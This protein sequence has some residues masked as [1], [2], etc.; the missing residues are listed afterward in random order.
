M[1]AW[2]EITAHP[3]AQENVITPTERHTP[4][5]AC[6]ESADPPE[7]AAR[8]KSAGG[9]FDGVQVLKATLAERHRP[10]E[11]M[12]Q[13]W[14]SRVG[15]TSLLWLLHR[16][17]RADQREI[18]LHTCCIPGKLVKRAFVPYL[19]LSASFLAFGACQARVTCHDEAPLRSK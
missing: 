17:T 16:I 6:R 19:L 11:A 18:A 12:T 9:P 13:V 2:T 10:A 5:F 8:S 1:I 4:S 15:V 14:A 3:T 7:P